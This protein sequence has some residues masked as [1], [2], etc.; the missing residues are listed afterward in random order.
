VLCAL[1]AAGALPALGAGLST[2]VVG[3]VRDSR[4]TPQMGALVQLLAADS[5]VIAQ[6][7][8]SLSGE[9]SFEHVIPGSYQMKATGTSFLPTLRENLR[10]RGSK[11]V[12][13]LTLNTL[14]EAIQWLPAEPRSPDEPEDDWKWTLRSSTN[15]PLLRFLEDGPLV[16]VSGADS[17]STP[18]LEARVAVSASSRQFG[19]SAVHS[20]FEVEHSRDDGGHLI[21]RADVGPDVSRNDQYMVGYEQPLGPQREIR[22]M[23]AVQQTPNIQGQGGSQDFEAVIFRGAETVNLG[24]NIT[25]AFGNQI[26]AVRG[27][28]EVSNS[29]PFAN[30]SWHSGGVVV[31]YSV[32]TSPVVESAD[33]IADSGTLAP[34]FSEVNGELRIEHGL[35]QEFRA[36]DDST[37]LRALVA[38]YRDQIDNPIISGG[39]YPFSSDYAGGNLLYDPL[40]QVLRATGPDYSASGFRAEVDHK[41][42]DSSWVSLG[43]AQGIAIVSP[44]PSSNASVSQALAALNAQRSEAVTAAVSGKIFRNNTYV[45][46]S[47]RWQ[48]AGTLTPVDLFDNSAQDAFLSLLIRQ[49]IRCGKLLPNGTEALIAVRNLLAEGY[50]PFLTPDGSTLYF[51][52]ANRSIEGGLSF[53]F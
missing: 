18:Q 34:Q 1:V 36:E 15:R 53:S 12:V 2:A 45:R 37:T 40:G 38:V 8:T 28:N 33:Q 23:V 14:F 51:A 47:Y 48:P 11:T 49:P 29:S 39:G 19:Q 31:A 50:R 17:Q 9:F 10:I 35:H 42:A 13:N 3:V 4:G 46:A 21:L 52:Q 26:Q 41:L 7:Y 22:T 27:P 44:V 25:A 32:A 43:Y 16:V 30:L 24:P 5:T 20:D 6:A